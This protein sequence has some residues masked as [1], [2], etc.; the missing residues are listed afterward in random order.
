MSLYTQRDKSPQSYSECSI[1]TKTF[2]KYR[3]K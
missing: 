3:R 2:F 1:S